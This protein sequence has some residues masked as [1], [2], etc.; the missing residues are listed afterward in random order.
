MKEVNNMDMSTND[1]YFMLGYD[2]LSNNYGNVVRM[3]N[4]YNS[5][6]GNGKYPYIKKYLKQLAWKKKQ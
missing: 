3:N 4:I 2:T 6:K 1:V 5:N